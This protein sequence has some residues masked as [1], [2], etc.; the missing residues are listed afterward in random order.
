MCLCLWV[1]VEWIFI[2]PKG[3][4]LAESMRFDFWLKFFVVSE[5]AAIGSADVPLIIG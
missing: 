5:G 4:R 2:F 3:A 1:E